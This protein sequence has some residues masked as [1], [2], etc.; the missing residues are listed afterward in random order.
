MQ[1]REFEEL[2]FT[3]NPS[4]R[5]PEPHEVISGEEGKLYAKRKDDRTLTFRMVAYDIKERLEIT[6]EKTILEVC[7]GAGQLVYFLYIYTK[8]L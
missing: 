1:R 7:C 8:K 3:P 6:P 2:G 5:I 4:N